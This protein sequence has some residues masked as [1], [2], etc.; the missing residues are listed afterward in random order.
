MGR[1]GFND[2]EKGEVMNSVQH[3]DNLKTQFE[4]R[5]EKNF[6]ARALWQVITKKGVAENTI[7][8][9]GFSTSPPFAGR[10][11]TTYV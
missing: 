9:L 2:T 3:S 7:D 6:Q 5:G 4:K 10:H 1:G 8:L 11:Q